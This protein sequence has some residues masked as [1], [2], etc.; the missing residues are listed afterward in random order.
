MP[1]INRIGGGA[2]AELQEKTASPKVITQFIE[3]DSGYDGL[4][5]V[6]INPVYL[7]H[8]IVYPSTKD[9]EIYPDGGYDGFSGVTVKAISPNLQYKN[10]T[11]APFKQYVEADSGYDGLST[12]MVHG[13]SLYEE[14]PVS[15]SSDR[16]SISFT[17]SRNDVFPEKIIVYSDFHNVS[18]SSS[19]IVL[20]E[21]FLY[22]YRVE[23]VQ[24]FWVRYR[25][26]DNYM[27]YDGIGYDSYA[28]TLESLGFTLTK[29]GDQYTVTVS[30]S[31]N[32]NFNHRATLTAHV[33]WM[34]ENW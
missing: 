30:D 10:V 22:R 26:A 23:Y 16:K 21:L 33:V 3:A 15:V 27:D 14:Q 24:T 8:Q 18:E 6:T 1:L 20:L 31:L 11:P 32:H 29:N 17:L 2:S 7:Q 5:K 4:K 19:N 12:V 34:N 25:D 28:E 13:A 9:Q